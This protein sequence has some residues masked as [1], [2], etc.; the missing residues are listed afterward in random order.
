M[1]AIYEDKN[2]RYISRRVGTVYFVICV[3]GISGYMKGNKRF[4][5]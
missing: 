3:E 5:K 4:K 1:Q 2:E